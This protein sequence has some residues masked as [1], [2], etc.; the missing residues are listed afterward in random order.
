M[1]L[2]EK[3]RSQKFFKVYFQ[4]IHLTDFYFKNFETKPNSLPINEMILDQV[5]T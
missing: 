3:F 2:S 5:L 1:I 4:A